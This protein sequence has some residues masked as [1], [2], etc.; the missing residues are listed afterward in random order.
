MNNHL[1][2][3]EGLRVVAT[4]L[5]ELNKKVVFVGGATVSLYANDP[6]AAE[7]RETRD[8]DAVVEVT[9][10]HEFSSQIEKRLRQ[11]GFTNDQ[12]SAVIC[13]Y[14]IHG[15]IVDIMPTDPNVLGFSNRWYQ[16]GVAQSITY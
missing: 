13:R 11:L 3:L 1:T 8:I 4:A 9:T 16:E 6:A 15:L 12:E 10:Y 7:P 2:N 14:K 5:A